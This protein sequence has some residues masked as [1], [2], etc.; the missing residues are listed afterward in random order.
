MHVERCIERMKNWHIFDK[1]LP[2]TLTPVASEMFIVI[3]ALTNFL[4]PLIDSTKNIN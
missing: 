2:I 4:P 3:E 1:R